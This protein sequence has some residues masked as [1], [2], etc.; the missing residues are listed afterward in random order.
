[1]KKALLPLF[2]VSALAIVSCNESPTKATFTL[3]ELG[4]NVEFHTSLQVDYFINKTIDEM[5]DFNY[6]IVGALRKSDCSAPEGVE[7][8]WSVKT[9]KGSLSSYEV[10]ISENEEFEN[11]IVIKTSKK[12][13]IFK[14]PKVNT[15]YYCKVISGKFES[16]VISFKTTNKGPR[17]IYVDGV[18]NVRDLGGFGYIK[19][20]L[21]YRGGAFESINEKTKELEINIT[22][23]GKKAIKEE[24]G[25]KTEVD[26]RK[27][28]AESGIIENCSLTKS[29]VEG[30]N[31]VAL[32]MY[33][34]GKN[35]LT[36]QDD[37]YDD[38]ARVK[39][40]INLL[41][42]EENYPLYF[43]CTHG[44]DRT[45]GLAYVIEALLGMDEDS[46]YRDYFFSNYASANDYNMKKSGI[47]GNYGKTLHEYK[48]D[49]TE[50]TLQ[51]RT[52]DYLNE[53]LEIPST[54]LDNVINIL[55]A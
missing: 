42:N 5:D 24:L 53:V 55:K 29:T 4:N 9:D 16:E 22:E 51:E 30:V 20:G 23:K 37:N 39:D 50:L 14:N 40:F 10:H 45:G 33:Y 21:L 36:Y 3:N 1:M 17:N 35:V 38:P 48:K 54:T 18:R 44:K 52:Y 28:I 41:A 12:S 32:P 49:N 46:M 26:V 34:G 19:Q 2:F 15:T 31:Y 47:D 13:A 25:I 8:K 11:E 27:N 7:I 43:H 6:M